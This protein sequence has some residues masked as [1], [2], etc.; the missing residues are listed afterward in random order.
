MRRKKTVKK[1]FRVLITFLLALAVLIAVIALASPWKDKTLPR[2]TALPTGTEETRSERQTETKEEN[3]STEEKEPFVVST[4]SLGVTGDILIHDTVYKS[5]H[6]ADGS[7]DFTENYQHIASYF[8]KFDYMVANLEVTLG[9]GTP[10][11]YPCFNCPDSVVDALKGAGVDL[12]LTANNHSYDTRTAGMKR[13]VQVVRE[14]GLENLGTRDNTEE[15]FYKVKEIGGI[16]VGM[17]CFTYST[18]SGDGVKSLNGIRMDRDANDLIA[19]FDYNRLDSFYAEAEGAIEEMRSYGAQALVFYLHWGNEYQYVPTKY[20]K[21]IARRLCEMGVDVIVGGHPH[22]IQPFETIVGDNG[23][24]TYCIYSTGNAISN[25]RKF[26]MDSDNYSG[27]TEDGMIFGVTFEKWSSGDVKI[28][29]I[30]ILPTW[31]IRESRGG[32][33]VFQIIP[34]DLSVADWKVFDLTDGTVKEARA[35]YDRTLKLVGE[36]LNEARAKQG[37]SQMPLTAGT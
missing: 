10:S 35:S 13:T 19:S 7:Y 11:A 4:A 21:D 12:L 15:S 14:K 29:E 31:V 24:E 28:R 25:Q 6:R 5:A 36:G 23:H 9:G 22:V 1:S 2:E 30:S 8:E 33:Y 37:L 16:R 18:L 32:R 26:L 20:Q 17:A 27:H 34:L 3:G